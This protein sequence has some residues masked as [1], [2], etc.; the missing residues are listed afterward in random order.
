MTDIIKIT[1]D[2][3]FDNHLPSIIPSVNYFLI[4]SVFKYRQNNPTILCNILV[5]ILDQF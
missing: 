4:K 5:V 2:K 3:F 1:D